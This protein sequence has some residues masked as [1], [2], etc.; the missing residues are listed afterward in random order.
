MGCLYR[1]PFG[2]AS[3]ASLFCIF[4][5]QLIVIEIVTNGLWHRDWLLFWVILFY[6]I[7][8][9]YKLNF[10]RRSPQC[11]YR[12]R[13]VRFEEFSGTRRPRPVCRGSVALCCALKAGNEIEHA[14]TFRSVLYFLNW[15][16]SWL[17][18]CRTNSF[19]WWAH[20][21]LRERYR[22]C[23]PQTPLICLWFSNAICQHLGISQF[24]HDVHIVLNP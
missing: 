21:C 1:K 3:V 6:F 10:H 18:S 2:H 7:F 16:L 24:Q 12:R 8:Y 5:E 15:N 14:A 13:A 17:H 20:E 19:V 23:S 4:Y 9:I 22:I 11:R